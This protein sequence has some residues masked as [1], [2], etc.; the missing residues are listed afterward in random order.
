MSVSV[1]IAAPPKPAAAS[2]QKGLQDGGTPRA[3]APQLRKWKKS[4]AVGPTLNRACRLYRAFAFGQDVV[5]PPIC[6]SMLETDVL[7]GA[8]VRALW[9][10]STSCMLDRAKSV[11]YGP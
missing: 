7:I 2:D 4:A 9:R 8:A 6:L 11:R 3:T 10:G 1:V 5:S